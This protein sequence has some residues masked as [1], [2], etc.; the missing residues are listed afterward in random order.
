MSEKFFVIV[1]NGKNNITPLTDY[2]ENI[3]LWNTEDEARKYAKDHPFAAESG[4]EIFERG[5]GS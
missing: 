3:K 1:N 4:F 2:N 5:T